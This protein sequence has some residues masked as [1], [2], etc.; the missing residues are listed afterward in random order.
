[1]HGSTIKMKNASYFVTEKVTSNRQ[2]EDPA[3]HYNMIRKKIVKRSGWG[4]RVQSEFSWDSVKMTAEQLTHANKKSA[5]GRWKT[6][7]FMLKM[8][9]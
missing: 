2:W 5:R 4:L 8:S 6:F 9:A 3:A 1:M 7:F